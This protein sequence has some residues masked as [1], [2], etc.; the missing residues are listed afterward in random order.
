MFEMPYF[1]P[2]DPQNLSDYYD[3][4]IQM[5][6]KQVELDLNSDFSNT[7]LSKLNQIKSFLDLLKDKI[8]LAEGY[9]NSLDKDDELVTDYFEIHQDL[10]NDFGLQLNLEALILKR[11][12][13]YVGSQEYS[14]FDFSFPDELSDR[15]LS[16]SMNYDGSLVA[17]THE[18]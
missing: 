11:V 15:F 2:I 1:G 17:I 3:S 6:E 12:G 8:K 13:I 5:E 18:S 14:I 7:D 4:E 9:L 16:V 10:E